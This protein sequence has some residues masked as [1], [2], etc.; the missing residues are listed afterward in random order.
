MD[1]STLRTPTVTPADRRRRIEVT[2]AMVACVLGTLVGTGVIGTPVAQ[3]AG[4][5]LA[6][7]ATRLA[8]AGP[9]FSIWT[10][11]YLGLA[12]YTAYQWLPAEATAPRHRAVGRLVAASMLLN[13]AWLLV[14]QAGWVWG[15][16]A[17]I[18][19]LVGVLG[20]LVR[21][22][23]AI[24]S[25]GVAETV[26]VDGTFGAYLG[27]VTV[28]VCANVTAALV[29]S[30][31]RV[32]DTVADLAAV[33]VLAVAAAVG[34]VLAR[35]LDGRWAVAVALAWGLGWVAVG[36]LTGEPYSPPVAVAALAA[37]VVVLVATARAGSARAL[38]TAG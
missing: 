11:I 1:A 5:A 10:V 25:Y 30:G 32:G 22:L 28:A 23:T 35:V 26:F 8:P 12:G 13:A 18:L 17:V 7:D 24:P 36:R 16:V 19:V 37:A 4:G 15:G 21:R 3:S 34:V 27:W 9:A 31:V 33:A 29:A 2:V 20:E 6:A 14:T 38:R